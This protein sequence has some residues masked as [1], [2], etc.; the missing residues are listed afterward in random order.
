MEEKAVSPLINSLT[1]SGRSLPSLLSLSLSVL[2]SNF[3]IFL[4]IPL[5]I[6]FLLPG[7][8]FG[9]LH[10]VL[11]FFIQR[12]KFLFGILNILFSLGMENMNL[13]N[14]NFLNYK[15]QD[16]IKLLFKSEIVVGDVV[17]IIN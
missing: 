10:Q 11:F 3:I 1:T 2:C 8:L 4:S 14:N 7:V 12:Y 17:Y 16:L 6:I 5:I 9:S 15:N 13:I